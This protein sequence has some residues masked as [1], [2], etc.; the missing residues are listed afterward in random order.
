MARTALLYVPGAALIVFSWLELEDPRRAGRVLLAAGLALIPA[1]AVRWWARAALALVIAALVLPGAFALSPLHPEGYTRITG[2]F[3]DGVLDYYGVVV[4]FDPAAHFRMHGALMVAVFAFC[5]A[6]ALAIAARRA[7]LASLVVAAGAAWPATLIPARNGLLLGFFVLA[8]VLLL[9]A[10]LSARGRI[11][12]R[13]AVVAG[14]AVVLA[15]IAATSSPSVAKSAF[16]GWQHWDPRHSGDAPVSVAYVWDAQYGGIHFPK[17]VTPVLRIA[18]PGRSLYWRATV[19]DAFDGARWVQQLRDLPDR[20]SDRG[21]TNVAVGPSY[22]KAAAKRKN[23][24]HQ[25]IE[26]EAL[27]DDH[28]IGASVPVAFKTSRTDVSYNDGGVA[29]LFGRTRRGERYEAWSYEPDPTA[30]QLLRTRIRYPAEVVADDLAVDGTRMPVFHAPGRSA[31]VA[32]ALA[33]NPGLAAYRPLWQQVRA[34]AA[35]SHTPYEA[36]VALEVWLRSAGGFAYDE[37]PPQPP[38]GVPPL[39]YFVTTSKAGYCQHFAGA[40][41]LMLRFLGIPARVAE[42]FTSGTYDTGSK[43][44]TVTDHDAH[45]WVEVWFDGYGWLPFDPTPTRGSLASSYTAAS[46]S[47]NGANAAK[48]LAPALHQSAAQIRQRIARGEGLGGPHIGASAGA[49]RHGGGSALRRNGPS[50]LLVLVLVALGGAAAIAGAKLGLRRSRYAS[51]D[52][53]RIARAC[54]QELIDFLRDQRLEPVPGATL[55]EVGE[56]LDEQ[57]GVSARRFVDAATAARFAPLGAAKT[58]ARRARRELRG[59]LR[60]I[61]RRLTRGERARGLLSLRSLGFR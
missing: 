32:A 6:L 14:V 5:L 34:L 61:R 58:E 43:I 8:V 7:A 15:A 2:R 3:W 30:A 60:E 19:L 40:M 25:T 29:T 16:L 41:A 4:P 10:G 22:P 50:L 46:L 59:V 9:F 35:T 47:F 21:L 17:K 44:W 11:A 45:A 39:A 56:T 24:I 52:P 33:A 42:G 37:Q 57:L 53:R 28:L 38:S 54:R 48:Q 1:L 26:V 31:R 13:P 51:R 18:G 20:P 23:W 27:E 36:A 12:A 55:A 49:G